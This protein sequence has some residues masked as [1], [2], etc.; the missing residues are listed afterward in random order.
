MKKEQIKKETK[1][2]KKTKTKKVVAPKK[3]KA[4]YEGEVVYTEKILKEAIL[5]GKA[6]QRNFYASH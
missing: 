4:K 5:S 6:F 1:A 2:A 3:T